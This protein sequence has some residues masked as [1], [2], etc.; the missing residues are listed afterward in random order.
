MVSA[1]E[2]ALTVALCVC[3]LSI[4]PILRRLFKKNSIE[5]VT[6]EWLESFSVDRYRPMAGL[7][8]E[9][10]FDFL[11]RQPGFDPSLYR[12]L[13]R[14]R[15]SIFRQYFHRLIG[16]FNKLHVA[17]RYLVARSPQDCSGVATQ[18]IRL[19]WRFNLVVVQVQMRFLLCQ[20]GL[21]TVQV[22]SLIAAL[23]GMNNQLAG[24]AL[25]QAA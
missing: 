12:K 19:Q 24:L 25:P 6:P 10:D 16:D 3:L 2:F 4:A 15:L 7:L 1:I 8:A 17:A 20:V 9:E 5:D 23:E 13:R 21:A 18:L 22:Q 14:E 11:S